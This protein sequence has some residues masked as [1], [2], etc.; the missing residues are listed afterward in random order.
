MAA[1]GKTAALPGVEDGRVVK[2]ISDAA[3]E[4]EK[5]RDRRMKLTEEES[6]ANERLVK[7]MKKHRRKVYKDADNYE[8][9]LVVNLTVKDP[10]ERAKVNRDKPKGEE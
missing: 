10:T 1:K 6:E 7:A 9:A 5:I 3:A 4:Y 8:P 2:E